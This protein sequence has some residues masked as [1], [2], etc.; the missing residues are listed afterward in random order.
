[1]LSEKAGILGIFTFFG[2]FSNAKLGLSSVGLINGFK[3]GLEELDDEEEEEGLADE[4][5]E[6]PELPSRVLESNRVE[7]EDEPPDD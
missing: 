2:P 6:V 4:S 1:M 7:L 3:L 5:P